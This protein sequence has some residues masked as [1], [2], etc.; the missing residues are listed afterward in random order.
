M[1]TKSEYPSMDVTYEWGRVA[2]EQ[3]SREASSLDNK[4]ASIFVASNVIIGI[5]VALARQI[6]FDLTLI[7]FG[8]GLASFLVIFIKSLQ[9]YR[10]RRFF[11]ADSPEILEEDYWKLEPDEAK[12]VYWEFVKE[13]YSRNLQATVAKGKT[14]LWTV[15]L[16]GI[17]VS[18]LVIW[19]LLISC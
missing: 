7:P 10:V 17:E 9:A 12:R 19:V 2:P 15:P 5:I 18:A 6:Q 11:V 4:I 14:L 3:L 1:E 13:H 8:I 16:L